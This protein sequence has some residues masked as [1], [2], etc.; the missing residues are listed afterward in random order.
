MNT[1]KV[2]LNWIRSIIE[3][4]PDDMINAGMTAYEMTAA[5]LRAAGCG[6]D[7]VHLWN[8]F[9]TWTDAAK[10]FL[11]G[12]GLHGFPI[13]PEEHTELLRGWG[14]NPT[15]K[16]LDNFFDVSAGLLVEVLREKGFS[17]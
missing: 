6:P 4:L 13:W 14:Y 15:Q 2:Q 1:R 17:F 8:G 7:G 11:Q 10:H 3:A 12:C 9:R 16:M 5:N